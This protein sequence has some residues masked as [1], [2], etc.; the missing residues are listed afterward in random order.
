LV[1]FGGL[2]LALHL[3][4]SAVGLVDLALELPK[5]L[6]LGDLSM[7]GHGLVLLFVDRVEIF[8]SND[9]SA[10]F[11]LLSADFIH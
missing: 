6:G 7:R 5:D 9:F 3:L 11:G 2:D 4:N 1:P 10:S 8:P